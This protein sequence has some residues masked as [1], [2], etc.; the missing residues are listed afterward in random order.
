MEIIQAGNIMLTHPDHVRL[1]RDAKFGHG[2]AYCAGVY[3]SIDDATVPLADVGFTQADGTYDVVSTSKGYFFRLEDHLDRFDRSCD[4]FALK[5]PHTRAETVEILENLVKMAGTKESYVWWGVTRGFMP[6]DDTRL[7]AAAYQNR[8]YAFVVPYVY[9]ADDTKRT[10]GVD[11][12]VSE[13]FIRIP[14]KAVDPRAKN[15]HWM[16]LK[17]SLFEAHK[18]G[19][20]WSV[21]C[22]ADGYLA[23]APGANIFLIK[24]NVL[25][26][27]D[28]GCLEGITRM[29]TMELA[30]EIGM[31]IREERVHVEALHNADE[32]FLTSTAGGIMPINAV[33]KKV[34]GGK[35]GPGETVTKLHN[36][37]WEKRWA[38]WLGTKIDYDGSVPESK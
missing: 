26:T 24:D 12:L 31:E 32:A 16:D 1:P 8:F 23:E 29:T 33:N 34:L 10:Q 17:L 5:N 28:S 15:F 3:S 11:L 27:P 21:L 18:K 38:G 13:D 19:F 6:E 7:N 2:S 36:L 22:D 9:I 30:K 35:Q 25:F 37:Y 20:E 14:P 4:L